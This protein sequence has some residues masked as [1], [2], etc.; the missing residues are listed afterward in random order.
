MIR[1]INL[2]SP[3]DLPA[4]MYSKHGF[5]FEVIK[6]NESGK[7]STDEETLTNLRL[8]VEN[9]ESPKQYSLTSYWNLEG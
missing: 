6:D 7:P 8:K 4:L 5:N 1:P 9:P 3:V 2:G